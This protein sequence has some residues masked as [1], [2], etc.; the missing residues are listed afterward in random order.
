VAGALTG[1]AAAVTGASSGIGAATVRALA[2]AGA[3]VAVTGR[4]RERLEALGAQSVVTADLG[5]ADEAQGFVARAHAELGRLDILVNCAGCLY[6][7]TLEAGSADEWREM[8]AINLLAAINC[9]YAAARAMRESGAGHIVNVSSVVARNPL[10][11]WSVYAATK[12][13]LSAFSGALRAE[14]LAD[15]IRV[16]LVEPGFTETE[17]TASDSVRPIVEALSAQRGTGLLQPTDVAEA[18]VF[19]LTR[20]P[21]MTL[22]ELVLRPFLSP[23]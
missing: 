14:M 17:M 15:N 21:R 18:I 16:T 7:G 5:N 13:G 4:R 19:A 1:R 8:A 23:S 3:T 11:Q 9:S 12:A 20:P 22:E 6:P 10:P 2:A